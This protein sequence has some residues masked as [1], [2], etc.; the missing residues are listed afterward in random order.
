M[1]NV[2]VNASPD[3]FEIWLRDAC[4][5]ALAQ[6]YDRKLVFVNS[7]NEWAEG[8]HLEPDSIYGRAYLDAVR[9]VTSGTS[10]LTNLLRNA[11][12]VSLLSREELE[13]ALR[14]TMFF[15]ETLGSLIQSVPANRRLQAGL[16]S[17]FTMAVTME[18]SRLVIDAINQSAAQSVTLAQSATLIVRG[19]SFVAPDF[20][21]RHG[22]TAFLLLRSATSAKSAHH[23]VDNWH[24]REDIAA[25]FG[26][27]SAD[28]FYGFESKCSLSDISV[29]L[30]EL[31][32]LE[33]GEDGPRLI[34]SH[35]SIEV[36]R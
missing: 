25:E 10:P 30:Y 24:S 13:R 23:F 9:R 14:Q 2:F 31:S 1:G 28:N 34:L 12:A 3:L 29:G 35:H 19:A 6:P 27:I 5:R 15:N 4:Q 17:E 33:F 7:W 18:D 11:D 36:I 20:A 32:M 21:A 26:V 22:R 8:A 16:P